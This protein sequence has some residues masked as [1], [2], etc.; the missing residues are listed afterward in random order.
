MMCHWCNNRCYEIK[1]KCYYSFITFFGLLLEIQ[2][3]SSMTLFLRWRIQRC[4]RGPR[5][6]YKDILS[7]P[8][9]HQG[10]TS[11]LK[12]GEICCLLF[13][14]MEWLLDFEVLGKKQIER[15]I[16]LVASC[17]VKNFSH[18]KNDESI[19]P[20]LKWQRTIWTG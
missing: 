1:K 19:T 10:E 14:L 2:I 5:Y 20:S 11:L 13:V 6:N 8:T 17:F 9:H 15:I 3:S 7:V 16:R 12:Q 4:T 18:V